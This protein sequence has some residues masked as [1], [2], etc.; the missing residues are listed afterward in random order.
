MVE[1]ILTTEKELELAEYYA[2]NGGFSEE[3]MNRCLNNAEDLAKKQGKNISLEL[4]R[5]R[6]IWD[7]TCQIPQTLDILKKIATH[8]KI[9]INEEIKKVEEKF[10]GY[11]FNDLPV[12]KINKKEFQ[13]LYAIARDGRD[14]LERLKDLFEG[15]VIMKILDKLEMSGL[16]KIEY[17]DKKIYGFMETTKGNEL[18]ESEEYSKW[19]K[20]CGD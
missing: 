18:L 11:S 5:I 1:K 14:N 8:R 6:S 15:Q 4:R 10:W 19:F 2:L 9:D 3:Y 16:I 7:E 20:E 17:R 13:V 12:I